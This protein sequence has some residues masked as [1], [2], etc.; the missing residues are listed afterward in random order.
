[1]NITSQNQTIEDVA[2]TLSTTPLF[3]VPD[4][5]CCAPPK[6]VA[7]NDVNV[8]GFRGDVVD[9]VERSTNNVKACERCGG[10]DFEDIRIH[11]GQSVRRDCTFCGRTWGFPVWY[12]KSEGQRQQRLE[13]CQRL[14]SGKLGRVVRPASELMFDY[15]RATKAA[16]TG[17]SM[18]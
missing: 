3:N 18:P 8:Q 6:G 10:L 1:M 5:V 14:L 17:S 15:R 12:G 11:D 4:V 9:E 13:R 7:R 16:A 2:R